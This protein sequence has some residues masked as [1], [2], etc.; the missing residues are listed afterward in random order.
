MDTDA[1]HDPEGNSIPTQREWT[2]NKAA[3]MGVHVAREY[4]EPGRSATSIDK[5]PIFQQMMADLRAQHR[6]RAKTGQPP[7]KYVIVYMMSR[8]FRNALEELLTKSELAKMGITLISAKENFGE[9]YLGDAMQ[10]IM[11]IFN[12]LQVRSNGEDVKTKMANKA[13]NG[14][15]VGRALIGYLNVRQ[16]HGGREV[17]TVGIDPERGPLIQTAFELYA[18]GDY[19]LADLSDEL[20]DRGLR[21]KPRSDRPMTQVGT[22]TLAEVLHDRYYLGYITHKG[23]E[24]KGRHE[25]LVTPDLF[26]RVQT[27]LDSRAAASERRRIHHHYLKGSLYCGHCDRER[28]TDSRMILQHTTNR[29]G[30]TYTH[31]FCRGKQEHRCTSSYINL[32]YVEDAVE[33][34]YET[35]RFTPDFIAT[36][37]THLASTIDEEQASTQLLH[38]QLTKELQTLDTKEENLLDLAAD[39][40]LPQ[41][42]I[43][44]RL[45]DIARQRERLTQKLGSATKDLSEAAQQLDRCLAKLTDLPALYRSCNDEQRRLLNQAIFE[46]LY[47][48]EDESPD[49]LGGAAIT[50]HQL[51]ESFRQLHAAQVAYRQAR[52]MTPSTDD[53]GI[54]ANSSVNLNEGQ[55]GDRTAD[56]ASAHHVAS[57]S[58]TEAP[59]G[60][61]SHDRGEQAPYDAHNDNRPLPA[62]GKEPV[63]LNPV[64]VLLADLPGMREV[65]GSSKASMVGDTGFEPVT[66]TVSR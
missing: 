49:A 37:R 23:E 35:I 43:K 19:S 66:S 57:I 42:K 31:F 26:E 55:A 47:I 59:E 22:S 27:I 34:H 32:V 25:P 48:E 1:D 62:V 40:E 29:H 33:R 41:G 13:R 65:V 56:N 36:A 51:N 38:Q 61:T 46:R 44:A 8:A 39:G 3:D 54:D 52:T 6:Q 64:D 20:Y 58:G 53:G 11:A 50:G 5:R 21:T 24:Y 30:T 10:G 45:K 16:R 17:R 63:S 15:T 12:E 18:T 7:I 60:D 4:V 2:R 14:G 9:G 28:A